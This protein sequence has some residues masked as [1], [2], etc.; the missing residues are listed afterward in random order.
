MSLPSFP[1]TNS[2]INLPDR[3]YAQG[4]PD[5]V[6]NP[7]LVAIN[8]LLA[9]EL[10]LPIGDFSEDQLAQIF[11]GNQV[12]EGAE[13]I[14]LAYAGHQFGHFVPQ[15]GDGRAILL[16]EIV[17]KKG[18]QFDIQLKGSGT[19]AF[20]RGGDGK[21]PLGPVIRE[22]IVSEAM[23]HLGVPT[24]RALAATTTGEKVF[25]E[26]ALP[27]GVFTRVAD[28]HIR[29][30]SFEYFAYKKDWEG[31]KHLLEFAV[32]RHYPEISGE[33]NLALAFFKKVMTAQATLIAH[34]MGIGFIHGVMN[35]DNTS[36]AGI[37]ID[38]G[39]CAFMD[40][41]RRDQVF[42][43]IDRQG[44]YA[45][46]NQPFI[47][48]WNLVRLADTLVPLVDSNSDA[49]VQLLENE[50]IKFKGL[51]ES[52]WLTR[53]AAKIGIASPKQEDEVLINKF[54]D[55]LESEE[56]DYTLG[57]RNLAPLLD[58][59]PS[60]SFKL[61]LRFSDFESKWKA[62]LKQQGTEFSQIQKRMNQ[63]NPLFIPRNHQIERAIQSAYKNDFSV[64]HEM[65]Q[66]L[67]SPFQDQPEF[68]HYARPPRPEENI[69]NTFCGT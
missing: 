9:E 48:N 59:N 15:L 32:A 5:Q 16:G 17:N 65:S 21:S 69:K 35:T 46:K 53:M 10:G 55:Y 63:N 29:V 57:F 12:P 26:E 44:R 31:V 8:R 18:K 27:G 2:Y 1:F 20:S 47:L 54:L 37:T 39:P 64:F 61:T 4:S 13:P 41:F 51:F 6:P 62:R 49:A 34:W 23:F 30:G 42:S 19:T 22:Y 45:Y 38:Y 11:S 36:V 14:S 40:H 3:F 50:L 25:R 56:L 67:S 43:Y 66:V 33:T 7:K 24:T 28:S 68:S 60:N 52:Q 58:S